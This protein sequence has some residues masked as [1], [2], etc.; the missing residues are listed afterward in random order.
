MMMYVIQTGNCTSVHV[1]IASI[2][3]LRLFKQS[4][5]ATPIQR[6]FLA[7]NCLLQVLTATLI[8]LD[9]RVPSVSLLRPAYD[10]IPTSTN[11]LHLR[12]II[13]WASCSLGGLRLRL[14]NSLHV[15]DTLTIRS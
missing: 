9:L 15:H 1:Q 4:H 10:A 14:L 6:I 11:Q 2:L 13:P 5:I 12:H 3:K 7:L 8:A